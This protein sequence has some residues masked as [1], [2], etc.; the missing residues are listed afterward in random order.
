MRNKQLTASNKSC[1]LFLT[2]DLL[3]IVSFLL[4]EDIDDVDDD[5]SEDIG[6]ACFCCCCCRLLKF[7]LKIVRFKLLLNNIE[8]LRIVDDDVFE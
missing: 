3:G 7:L 1:L 6:D 4:I 5:D 2:A 8:L